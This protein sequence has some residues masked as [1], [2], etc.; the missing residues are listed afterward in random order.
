VS[1]PVV[2]PLARVRRSRGMA[3]LV[4][5]FALFTLCSWLCIGR[6]SSLPSAGFA[7]VQELSGQVRAAPLTR[8]ALL[9]TRSIGRA[10]L[11]GINGTPIGTER[12][13]I[14]IIANRISTAPGALNEFELVDVLG[15]DLRVSVPV[16]SPGFWTLCRAAPDL[17]LYPIVALSFAALGVWVWWKRPEERAAAPLLVLMLLVAGALSLS[18]GYDG[19]SRILEPIHRALLPLTGPAFVYFGLKFTG[20]HSASRLWHVARVGSGLALSFSLFQLWYSGENS[21]VLDFIQ[22]AVGT[23]LAS[24][25]VV[26]ASLG[27]RVARSSS[28]LALRRRG[29][30]LAKTSLV[31]FFIPALA[32]LLPDIPGE[33]VA[34]AVLLLTFPAAMA[35]A[36]VRH[37]VFNLRVVLRQGF[38][39]GLL[40]VAGLVLYLGGS[41]AALELAHHAPEPRT[42]AWILAMTAILAASGLQLRLQSA[43]NRFV[44]RS[45]YL[46]GDAIARASAKLA[47]AKTRTAVIDAVR[48]ALLDQLGLT[49]A[50]LATQGESPGIW[51][52]TSLGPPS[53]MPSEEPCVR[54]LPVRLLP[55][56]FAP[57][58][59]ALA[60]QR[61]VTAY[62]SAAASAQVA[63]H[64]AHA[65]TNGDS[66]DGDDEATFWVRYGLEAVVPLSVGTASAQS[67]V[68]GLLC[69]G[70]KRTR[71]P[72]DSA[73]ERLI[74]T[75]ANQLAVALEN[76]TAFD[77]IRG[78]K[79]G[80]EQQVEQRTRDLS[81]ALS[82]LSRAQGQ[83]IDSEKQ[84]ML[85]RLVAGMVHEIN[86]PLGTLRS[87]VD[88]LGRLARPDTSDGVTEAGP[89]SSNTR[90]AHPDTAIAGLLS[91][92]TSSAD[93]LHQLVSRLKRFVSLDQSG[94]QA[95]D[96]RESI[97]SALLVL[98]PSLTPEITIRQNYTDTD[99]RIQGDRAKLNQLFWNLLQNSLTALNGR[100]EIRIEAR[101]DDDQIA[102]D[103]S[104]DGVGIPEER[105]HEVFDFGFTQKNGRVGL[106]LGLPTSKLTVDELGG[107][108]SI[109]SAPGRGTSV[110]L[111]LPAKR[112]APSG[113]SLDRHLV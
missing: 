95:L 106:R 35:Y 80:L 113:A 5:L 47:G 27:L 49:R 30:L 50:A 66:A 8:P 93:R 82:D 6:T 38:V 20:H 86:T 22:V 53:S 67:R 33:G 26:T 68:V 64:G 72:L 56:R 7:F 76:A 28:P 112:Q 81:K 51:Q 12:D 84:A 78:L 109:E 44:F 105:L 97:D 59:R 9:A 85:G 43:I 25:V 32:V 91:V 98:A 42:L 77:E 37:G 1:Q 75:L 19:T 58:R 108:I 102:V 88:T 55:G 111:R 13:A 101:R 94:P 39:H 40:S 104:D 48:D 107:E 65:R 103:L 17:V 96:V 31:A 18:W 71:Q 45:R 46:F 62:D 79:D 10:S 14:A 16:A 57:V 15:R 100:G 60:T 74:F 11:R 2:D 87:S 89:A 41:L 23:L 34:V 92:I 83:L 110:R 99:L 36:I 29:R 21:S 61:I 24:C 52:C 54:P 70:P 73:D 3:A 69:L 63:Q 4:L 90:L